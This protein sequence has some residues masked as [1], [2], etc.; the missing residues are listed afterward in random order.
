MWSDGNT[1]MLSG[2]K[3]KEVTET[4]G[5]QDEFNIWAQKKEASS[6]VPRFLI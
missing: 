3:E 4:L 6:S 1:C 5:L 2:S